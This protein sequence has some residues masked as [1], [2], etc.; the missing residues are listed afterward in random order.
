[1]LRCA[2][3]ARLGRTVA[4]SRAPFK[5]RRSEARASSNTH[6]P[7]H[8]QWRSDV[9]GGDGDGDEDEEKMVTTCLTSNTIAI[10]TN[11]HIH[12]LDT[13]HA[14]INHHHLRQPWENHVPSSSRG[15]MTSSTSSTQR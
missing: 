10:T 12:H 14:N 9:A 15:S 2:T 11:Y 1:M 5:E 3:F 13:S 4:S 7:R 6:A 8:K